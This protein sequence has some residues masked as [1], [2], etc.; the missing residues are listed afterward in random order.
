MCNA[1]NHHPG[2]TCGWG[3]EGHLGRRTDG[4]WSPSS[5]GSTARWLNLSSFTIPN[6]TCPVCKASVF[7]YQS[8][9]GGRVF[10][11]E[12][13]P[14]W[15]KHPCTDTD[16]WRLST[17]AFVP[18]PPPTS[19]SHRY[20]WQD[21]GW[22]PFLPDDIRFYAPDLF[23]VGGNWNGRRQVVYMLRKGASAK[24]DA[25][26]CQP[27]GLWQMKAQGDAFLASILAPAI[28]PAIRTVYSSTL[29]ARADLRRNKVR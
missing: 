26:D 2:C 21:Q 27:Y 19:T 28:S 7:Y 6:A 11:D 16:T 10:F 17:R 20:A 3:G 29:A 13:G 9:D 14:P 8:P 18:L 15:P 1:W 12:L 22:E 24:N 25:R 4:S 5:A 23:Y